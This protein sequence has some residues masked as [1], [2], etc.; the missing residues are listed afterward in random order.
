MQHDAS[1]DVHLDI[2]FRFREAAR[3]QKETQLSFATRI[4]PRPHALEGPGD[5]GGTALSRVTDS[6][7]P[8]LLD[9]RKRR[10]PGAALSFAGDRVVTGRHKI[11]AAQQRGELTPDVGR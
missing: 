7:I 2:E 5:G 6:G 8:Q 4:H 1:S 10:C 9:A 11:V 3:D